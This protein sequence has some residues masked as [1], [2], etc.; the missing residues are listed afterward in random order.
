M[1]LPR[2]VV[3]LANAITNLAIMTGIP[4]PPYT[5]NNALVVE[6]L[7]RRS[8]K[9]HRIP[10]GYLDDN[11]RIIVVVE[12]GLRANW[13]RNAMARDGRLR[14]H[15]RGRWREARLRVLDESP[16]SYLT[17]MNRIHAGF[18]RLEASTPGV[19]ELLLDQ[20]GDPGVV[21][22][23]PSDSGRRQGSV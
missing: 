7:G 20:T 6:T 2:P 9:R 13:V 14:I 12:D 1:S 11:G 17:R 21:S 23:P 18:V 15:L 22:A 8:G 3:R 10:V 4:R 5:R 19:V 16:E